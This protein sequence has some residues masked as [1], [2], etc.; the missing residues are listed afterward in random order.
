MNPQAPFSCYMNL[1]DIHPRIKHLRS[2]LYSLQ[3]IRVAIY[4][5]FSQSDLTAYFLAAS[6]EKFW[7]KM[8]HPPFH[9]YLTASPFAV[10]AS[11]NASS[12]S[13]LSGTFLH[14]QVSPRVSLSY[15]VC[16]CEDSLYNSLN[17]L[18]LFLQLQF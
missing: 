17:P 14:L 10:F 1:F 11:F 9:F 3:R 8:S 6:S 5:T 16:F 12:C 15:S 2:I 7:V 18:G 13:L 4:V